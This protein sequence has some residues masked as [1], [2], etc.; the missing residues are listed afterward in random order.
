MMDFD[1]DSIIDGD[2]GAAFLA[3]YDAP[4]H[5]CDGN[6]QP[7]LEE[8]LLDGG[9]DV[10]TNGIPDSCE[11]AGDVNGDG[12]VNAVDLVTVILNWGPCPDPGT[13]CFGD[14]T[15]DG[16]INAVDLVGVILGWG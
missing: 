4:L 3:A 16:V 15:G 12:V 8:V 2:D 9:L 14:A 1:G 7:D 11:G 5:D 6:G 13:P 10:N